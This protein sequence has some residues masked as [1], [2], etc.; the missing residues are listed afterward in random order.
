MT[1]ES[2][3]DANDVLRIMISTDNHLGYGEKDAVRGEDSFLAFEEML[4]LAVREDVD[5]ILLGGDLF[6]D[7][8]PSQNALH[9]CMKLLRMY[10]FGD[11]PITVEFL[12]DGSQNFHNAVNETVNYEDPNLNISIPVY[13]IHG[14]HDDPSVFGGLSSLDLLSTT[15]LVNYFGRWTDLTRIDIAPILLKKGDTK[16]ALYGLSHIQ[17]MRLARLFESRKVHMQV[18]EGGEGEWFHLM[19]LHQNRA[20]RGPKNYL[21]EEALPDFLNLV[22]WGHEHDC[23]I[24]P[25]H[26]VKRDFYVCQPGSTVPTSLA[27][28]ESLRKHVAVLEIYKDKFQMK[29]IPLQTVRPFVFE[30]V[31]IMDLAEELRLDE[32]DAS[33]K[34]RAMAE[35]KVE[36][37]L[38]RA[39]QLLTGHPKQPTLPSIRLRLV[40]TDEDQMFNGIRLGQMFNE[41]VANPGDMIHFKKMIKKEKKE[42]SNFDKEEMKNQFKKME[43]ESAA[44]VE[45]LVERYF[46][47]VDDSKALKVL[48][49]KALTEICHQLVDRKDNNAADNLI[50]SYKAKAV[51][52]L[53][54]KMPAEDELDVQ[55]TQFKLNVTSDDILEML[56]T[57]HINTATKTSIS[58]LGNSNYN[59]D[60]DENSDEEDDEIPVK[61]T[62]SS[63]S[64]AASRGSRARGR[65]G[66]ATTTSKTTT[67]NNSNTSRSPAGRSNKHTMPALETSRATRS[68]P[69]KQATLFNMVGSRS[70]QKIYEVSDSDSD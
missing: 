52:Y 36:V 67:S 7:A 1:S 54:D 5:F 55:L 44:R 42:K 32:G 69:R 9:K 11:R 33:N 66:K 10:T 43:G 3:I 68:S 35:E 15:G 47:E 20:D 23:R 60:D 41:R 64:A 46:N 28:G 62:R 38:E 24:E 57:T 65:G 51:E 12:S 49:T 70:K 39:K 37:M 8:V 45:D 18:P 2:D 19:V 58:S 31:N 16:L 48:S 27:E 50:R 22:I 6:H 14:N 53:M 26:N 63:A 30:S 29:P 17:D 13:S 59:N 40:F 61:Q 4:E 56:S 21:P 25:E 34:V